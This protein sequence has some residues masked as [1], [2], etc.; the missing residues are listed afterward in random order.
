[1]ALHGICVFASAFFYACNLLSN[2]RPYHSVAEAKCL[3]WDFNWSLLSDFSK[4][5]KDD[6]SL[7]ETISIYFIL[8]QC[9][10]NVRPYQAIPQLYVCSTSLTQGK[11]L[12]LMKRVLLYERSTSRCTVMEVGCCQGIYNIKNYKHI[13]DYLRISIGI[14][15]RHL[16][17]AW[18]LQ[19]A[20][21]TR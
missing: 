14:P 5:L 11:K 1:M 4:V 21:G 7:G 19:N 18:C 15:G 20:L 13:Q 8:V 12:D 3:R 10:Q 17:M 2:S 6:L 16:S 9:L